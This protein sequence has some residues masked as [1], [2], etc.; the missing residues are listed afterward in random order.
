M[1]E[2]ARVLFDKRESLVSRGHLYEKAWGRALEGGTR[3]VD[4]HVSRVRRALELDGRHGWKL[5]SIYQLGYRLEAA[6]R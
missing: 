4:T 3:T 2:I 1:Y 5:S 6:H